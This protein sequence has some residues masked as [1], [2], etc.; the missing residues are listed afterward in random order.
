MNMGKTKKCNLIENGT[1]V[2]AVKKYQCLYDKSFPVLHLRLPS[3]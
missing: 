2:E 3:L 1:L